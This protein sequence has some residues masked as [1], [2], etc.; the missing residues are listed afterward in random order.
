MTTEIIR[1][2]NNELIIVTTNTLGK[3]DPLCDGDTG[4]PITSHTL[5]D[6]SFPTWF[7]RAAVCAATLE[8]A[9]S[10]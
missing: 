10:S 1:H 5:T 8:K 6:G 2:V 9:M 3:P 4:E 7:Y